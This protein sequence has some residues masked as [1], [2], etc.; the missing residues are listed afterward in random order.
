MKILAIH[1]ALVPD[2]KFQSPVD[3][4]RVYRPLRELGKHV[5]WQIDHQLGI[6]PKYDKNKDLPEF[7][8][9]EMEE[10]L[11]NVKDYDIVFSSY[12]PDPTTYTLLKVARD[13][14]GVQF[15][16]DVDD[17]MFAINPDN[18]YWQ[19]HGHE[20]VYWMQR[21]IADNDF[22]TTPSEILAG[23]FRDRRPDKAPDSVFVLPNYITDDYQNPG[24]DNGDKILI[25]YMGGSSHYFDL[26]DSG[27][28]EALERIMHE[29]KNVHFQTIGMFIEKYLPKARNH[30]YPGVRGIDYITKV[31]PTMNFNIALAP[32]LQ[33]IFNEGKSNI[34]WQEY[35]RAGSPVIAS[36]IGP[37]KPLKN[38]V[39][40][41]LVD[42]S[43]DAWYKAIKQLLDSPKLRSILVQNAQKSAKMQRLETNW[44]KYQRL[45]EKV[46]E[47]KIAHAK[48]NSKSRLVAGKTS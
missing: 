33:N 14:Y 25:G 3:H 8:E 47:A 44:D 6:I 15:V 26:N 39:D 24:F 7:T 41:I 10:G 9:Q 40:A 48:S 30:F 21:M 5:D 32:L 46:M 22:I 35:T 23:R 31:F 16:M 34:K 45:F 18:P 36:N 17:D 4:W 20:Q 12:M 13:R 11:K 27:V 43:S 19:K 29:Y 28:L 42:N 38:G 37:Y 2:S 1:T